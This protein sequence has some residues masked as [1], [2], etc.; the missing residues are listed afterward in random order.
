MLAVRAAEDHQRAPHGG[1]GPLGEIS[2][3]FPPD[4]HEPTAAH[5]AELSGLRIS[6]LPAPVS[7][8][9]RTRNRAPSLT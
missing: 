8:S 2:V 3:L 5:R 1:H 7:F 9:V 4:R 6:H